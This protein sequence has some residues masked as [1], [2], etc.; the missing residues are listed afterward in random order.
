MAMR[1][2]PLVNWSRGGVAYQADSGSRLVQ[3]AANA[4]R[5]DYVPG[6]RARRGY[7]IEGLRTNLEIWSENYPAAWGV[8]AGVTGVMDAIGPDG[9][10]NSAGTVTDPGASLSYYFRNI[11]VPDDTQAYTVSGYVKKTTG[12]PAN[13]PLLFSNIYIGAPSPLAG[14]FVDPTNG[15]VVEA[16][17]IFSAGDAAGQTDALDIIDWGDYWRAWYTLS[18]NASGATT[19]RTAWVPAGNADG[20][21]ASDAA[22]SGSSG[23]FGV[24]VEA[25]PFPSSVIRTSGVQLARPA[26]VVTITDTPWL[27][28][29]A[30]TLLFEVSLDGVDASAHQPLVFLTDGTNANYIGAQK[31]STTGKVQA[32]VVT[33]SVLEANM[34]VGAV[35]TP[36][37]AKKI[38]LTWGPDYFNAAVDGVVGTPD[39]SV[40]IPA[41][42][43]VNVG[44]DENDNSNMFGAAKHLKFLPSVST[45][46]ELVSLTA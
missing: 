17:T 37:V 29:T 44:A 14:I 11:T 13:Y 4:A 24:D 26:D 21:D 40:T 2:S 32:F 5:P 9:V 30:G 34:T 3:V 43:Q 39:T 6:T 25:G 45:D 19:L 27:N 12:T 18:N 8:S 31:N 1:L 36:G 7:T 28:A 23:F 41:L 22:A 33:A 16:D 46:A 35:F 15:T 42:S 38:A 10:A 20:T